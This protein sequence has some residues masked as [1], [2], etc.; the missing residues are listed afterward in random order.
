MT[1]K[2]VKMITTIIWTIIFFIASI[3]IFITATLK[4]GIEIKSLNFKN[5]KMQKLYVKLDKK[6]IVKIDKIKQIENRSSNSNRIS[7]LNIV[8]IKEYLENFKKAFKSIEISEI[9]IDG[10]KLKLEYKKGKFLITTKEFKLDTTIS[11]KRFVKFN[12]E[13]LFIK[14]FN[15]Y[16]T[17]KLN[18]NFKNYY[19]DGSFNSFDLKGK[20]YFMVL[21]KKI[22]FGIS[23]TSSSIDKLINFINKKFKL[24]KELMRWAYYNLKYKKIKI[25]EFRGEIVNNRLDLNKLSLLATI[26][27]GE[28]K[29]HHLL[30]PIETEKII[31]TFKSKK[32]KIS[33]I[34]P[35]MGDKNLKGSFVTISDFDKERVKIEV[36]IKTLSPFDKFIHKILETYGIKIDIYQTEGIT[37]GKLKLTILT[38]P[39][40]LKYRGRFFIKRGNIDFFGLDLYAENSTIKLLNDRVFVDLNI[41]L[42]KAFYLD[43]KLNGYYNIKSGIFV[44]NTLIRKFTFNIGNQNI[45][46]IQNKK[47]RVYYIDFDNTS[48]IDLPSLKLYIRLK[49]NSNKIYLYNAD[50]YLNPKLK[51]L[52]SIKKSNLLIKTAD[53]ENFD[54]DLYLKQKDFFIQK[55]SKSDKLFLNILHNQNRTIVKSRDNSIYFSLKKDAFID[56]KGIRI[57]RKGLNRFIKLFN[58]EKSYKERKED[59]SIA[60]NLICQKCSFIYDENLSFLFDNL[61]FREKNGRFELLTNIEKSK[62]KLEKRDNLINLN[63]SNIEPKLVN[64]F[65]KR[66]LFSKGRLDLLLNGDINSYLNGKLLLRELNYNGLVIINNLFALINTIPALLTFSNPG[67]SKDGYLIRD[68]IV[69]FSY[70]IKDRELNFNRIITKSDAFSIYGNGSLSLKREDLNLNLEIS[71]LQSLTN[72]IDKIPI[73]NYIILGED[74]KFSFGVEVNG[75]LKKPKIE[76]HLLRD[77]IEAPFKMVGRVIKLL[78]GKPKER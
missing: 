54:I 61:F 60:L 73:I 22:K 14:K 76:T 38:N 48:F 52:L 49:E 3:S 40:D 69:D 4:S 43:A 13:N 72:V 37:E 24:P 68:G 33:L 56:L 74:G 42:N 70:Q 75:N 30:E 29:F 53:F 59:S 11:H 44:A 65:A 57:E 71:T 62:I 10:L 7:I 41:I 32:L 51:R 8:E 21:D 25:E 15:L 17:G 66:E 6:F 35:K 46:T 18:T 1:A 31:L 26:Y 20:L 28:Y 23:T 50:N 47:S 63:I 9:D 78:G 45:S 12:I 27:K 19:F 16:L 58:E 36:N 5:I 67:Y 34:K 2:I 55:K 77:L 64:Y 39:F